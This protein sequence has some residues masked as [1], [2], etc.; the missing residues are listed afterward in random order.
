MIDVNK[1]KAIF[2]L[3]NEG[4]GLREISRQLRIS[5]NTVRNIINQKGQLPETI[6]QDKIN[7]DPELLRKLHTK[8][9]GYVQRIHEILTEEK[10]ILIGYST[11]TR[12]IRELNLGQPKNQRCDQ[13]PD[14]A[15]PVH[16][17]RGWGG[18]RGLGR[19]GARG[20]D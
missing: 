1:R 11:L 9:D 14:E 19:R 20:W 3:H 15:G 2:L 5:I 17:Y 8:C 16:C 6:R 4:M 7:I 10:S 12:T 18:Q 13:Q